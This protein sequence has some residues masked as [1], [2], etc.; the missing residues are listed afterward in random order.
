MPPP[1]IP[2]PILL[3]LVLALLLAFAIDKFG[4]LALTV[5]VC[6]AGLWLY[7]FGL[8]LRR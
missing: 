3:A 8:W 4:W 5:A 7:A 6:A 2:V 1:M